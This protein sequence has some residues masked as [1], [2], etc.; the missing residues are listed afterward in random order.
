MKK[1]E[2]AKPEVVCAAC[3]VVLKLW[4]LPQNPKDP[5]LCT[6]HARALSSR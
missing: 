1:P 2:V 4:E 6:D 3:G 5:A